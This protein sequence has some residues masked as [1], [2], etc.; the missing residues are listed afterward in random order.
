MISFS[1]VLKCQKSLFEGDITRSRS[2][3]VPEQYLDR[4]TP[5]A[6]EHKEMSRS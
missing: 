2:C 1:M 5:L 4:V 3:T 6:Y